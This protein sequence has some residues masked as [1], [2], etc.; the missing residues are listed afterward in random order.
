M[1]VHAS[2]H[3]CTYMHP[4]ASACQDVACACKRRQIR[5]VRACRTKILI[6]LRIQMP[7]MWLYHHI[8]KSNSIHELRPP[9]VDISLF[10]FEFMIIKIYKS[11]NTHFGP[12]T[13][14]PNSTWFL[15]AIYSRLSIKWMF[16]IS[17]KKLLY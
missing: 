2:A 1:L 13:I 3:A 14:D 12:L 16:E 15:S 6:I 10:Q 8:L 7:R 17:A 9:G 4:S 5:I 11:A